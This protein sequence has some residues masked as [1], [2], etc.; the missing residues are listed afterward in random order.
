MT[1]LTE[2]EIWPVSKVNKSEK[3]TENNG[4]MDI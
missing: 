4:H 1:F 2:L 3:L